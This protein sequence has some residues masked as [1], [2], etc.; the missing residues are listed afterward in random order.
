MLEI[1]FTEEGKFFKNPESGWFIEFPKGPLAIGDEPI[2]NIDEI[3]LITGHLKILS[4]TDSV[5]DRLSA[6]YHWGD[7]QCLQQAVLI[8]HNSVV[9]LTEIERW[10]ENEGKLAQFKRFLAQE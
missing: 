10:S 7:E 6:F 3:A 8:R 5:K 4:A 2:V 1:G 9:D